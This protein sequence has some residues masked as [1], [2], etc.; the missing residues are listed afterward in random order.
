MIRGNHEDM[1]LK[2]LLANVNTKE[3]KET[4][5]RCLNNGGSWIQCLNSKKKA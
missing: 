5:Q 3:G 1:I 4:Y 2:A